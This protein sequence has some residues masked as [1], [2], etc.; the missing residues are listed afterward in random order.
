MESFESDMIHDVQRI[1][2]K[3]MTMVISERAREGR[4]VPT[5]KI[6][7][8]LPNSLN[9]FHINFIKLF[10]LLLSSIYMKI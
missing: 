1:I 8:V 2:A 3:E 10:S 7:E 9:P 6:Y 4:G 5:G